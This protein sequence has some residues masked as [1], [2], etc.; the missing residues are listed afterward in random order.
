M[1][2]PV[3]LHTSVKPQWLGT[4]IRAKFMYSRGDV[5]MGP[6]WNLSLCA[7]FYARVIPS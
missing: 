7:G 5:Y 1:L 6:I 3:T 2:D 4:V